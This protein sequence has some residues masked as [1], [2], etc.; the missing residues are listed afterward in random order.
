M[1]TEKVMACKAIDSLNAWGP[2]ADLFMVLADSREQC[3][4]LDQTEREL[5][6]KL[7]ELG[8]CLLESQVKLAGDGDMGEV[9]EHSEHGTLVRSNER[10]AKPYQSIFGEFEILRWTYHRREGQK[11]LHIPLDQSLGLPEQK[12]SYV[13]EDWLQR[14]A[15]HVPFEQAVT[16]LRELLG[17]KT[18]VRSAER[19]NRLLAKYA[20]TLPAEIT[21]PPADTEG[22]I[23][24]V[25]VDGKGVPMKRSLDE[26][27]HEELGTKLYQPQSTVGYEK[28]KKRRTAGANKSRKQMAYVS[29]V[30]SIDPFIRNADDI[31]DEIARKAQA[32]N[33]PKPQNKTFFAEMTRFVDRQLDEGPQRL[34]PKLTT[35][36]AARNPTVGVKAVVCLMDGQRSLWFRQKQFLPNAI[37]IIDIFHVIEYLW[38]AAYCHHPQGSVAAEQ[39]VTKYLRR[40]LEGEVSNVL[41]S[42]QR[43]LA[44][45][46]DNKAKEMTKVITY[47]TTNKKHMRYDEYLKSGYPIGSGVVEGACR[48]VVKDRMELSGMRWEIEGAQ[49]MLALRT[50][51]LN[52][53]WD[54]LIEHRIRCEQTALY[55]VAA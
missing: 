37:P 16:S 47:L 34:F 7:L 13:L 4:R 55:S 53:N 50:T 14:L 44:Q 25:T 36:L 8:R 49:S 22:S 5:L 11:A 19:I 51:F 18:S 28:T 29:V 31:L 45:L 12:Q 41:R 10:H 24:V 42:F 26:R 21:S 40:I 46:K 38:Q 30:Y 54:R 9:L 35:E 39:Y 2:L 23:L 17:I 6:V 43:Q 20:E 27:K 15:I 32:I 3:E 33:R 1:L 48:H 52:K